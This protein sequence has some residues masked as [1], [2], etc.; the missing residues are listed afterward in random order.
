MRRPKLDSTINYPSFYNGQI[1]EEEDMVMFNGC[2]VPFNA[3]EINT[4]FKL[5]DNLDAEGNQLVAST[6]VSK[7]KMQFRVMAKPGSK[8]DVSPTGIRTLPTNC[9]LPEANLWVYFVKKRLIPTT[10]D[11]M[12]SRDKMMAAYCIMQGIHLDVR[13]IIAA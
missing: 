10:H 7:C 5:R 13:R 12:V 2:E 4:T 3:R 6:S 8:W 9:L 11:K 1:D